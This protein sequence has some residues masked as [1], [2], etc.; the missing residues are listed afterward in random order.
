MLGA[1]TGQQLTTLDADF[2]DQSRDPSSQT[3]A[4]LAPSDLVPSSGP[5][6]SVHAHTFTQTHNISKSKREKDIGR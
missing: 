6:S 2:E 4:T 5:Q 3:P 1:E